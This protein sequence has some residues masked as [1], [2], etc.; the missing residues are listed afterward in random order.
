E[1]EHFAYC[2]RM[3]QKATTSEDKKRWREGADAP[4]CH[5]TIAMADAIIALTANIA[6][7]RNQ[8]IE[9]RPEWFAPENPQTPE[10]AYNV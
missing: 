9:Y 1:M 3:H 5:G 4:R 10:D 8:R 6:M 2:V 7:K